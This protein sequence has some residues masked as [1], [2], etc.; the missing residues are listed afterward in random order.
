MNRNANYFKI[1]IFVL[2]GF[3]LVA[4]ALIYLGAGRM[5]RPRFFVET[6]V[7][8][9]VQGVEVGTAVKFR[10][11][12]VGRVSEVAF[13]F[14]V[15]PQPEG[16]QDGRRD[17]VVV[18]LEIN[19]DAFRGLMNAPNLGEEIQSL[20]TQGLRV[21]IQPQGITGLNFIELDYLSPERRTPPLKVWWT[22]QNPYIP[23]A[24]GTLTSMLDSINSIMDTVKGLDVKEI[25]SQLHMALNRANST[26][27]ELSH[28]MD[29]VELGKIS[30]E[31]RGLIS[32]TRE[33]VN[34]LQAT[35]LSN[36]GRKA[37]EAITA[38]AHD[39]KRITDR[40]EAVVDKIQ[41]NPLLNPDEIGAIV[42][43]FRASAANV[44]TLTENLREYPSQ[45]L[46][47]EPPKR[48][49]FDPTSPTKPRR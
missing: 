7:D 39:A 2:T 18:V 30:N 35:E 15:Y 46:L 22:P 36:N 13:T 6:Y 1:G 40:A 49:P 34:E 38:A 10:G 27:V 45:L 19:S 25:M 20:V 14:N 29:Q 17:Y 26:L 41:M 8:G 43:D 24:P 48:S 44:R 21:M 31:L 12:T 23:S 4:G 28:K 33:K 5:F 47:G 32:D 37:L 16:K 11:V 3:F 9:T 42:S